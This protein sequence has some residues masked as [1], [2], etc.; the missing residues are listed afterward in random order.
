MPNYLGIDYGTKRIGLAWADELLISLPAG[1]MQVECKGCR[2]ARG[3]NKTAFDLELVVG[4]PD[5]W[6]AK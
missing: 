5:I 6:M 3:G 4:Y 1:A 2:E